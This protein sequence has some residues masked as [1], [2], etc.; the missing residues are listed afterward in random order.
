MDIEVG[1][2]SVS[3]RTPH[4]KSGLQ[5]VKQRAAR[6][7][8]SEVR[9]NAGVQFSR[10]GKY[11][12]GWTF[13]ADGDDVV[14]YNEGERDSMSHLLENGHVVVD[15]NGV[16]HGDWSASEEHIKPAFEV[17]QKVYLQ[18]AEDLI[19]DVLKEW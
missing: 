6:K 17:A 4:L 14:V 16:L 3:G 2:E 8:V 9:K 5:S 12:A 15:R 7:M 19:D 11:A 1:F 13:E 10:T 18:A